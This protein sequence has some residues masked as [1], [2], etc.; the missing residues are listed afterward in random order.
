MSVLFS[1]TYVAVEEAFLLLLQKCPCLYNLSTSTL[2]GKKTIFLK[3]K[4]SK[5]YAIR[6]FET[7]HVTGL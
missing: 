5:Y 6:L 7:G 3:M 2:E 1:G 4:V